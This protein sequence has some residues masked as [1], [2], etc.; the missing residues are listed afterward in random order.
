M[1]QPSGSRGNRAS[2]TRASPQT[3]WTSQRWPRTS[4]RTGFLWSC[5]IKRF[6]ASDHW[7]SWSELYDCM[8]SNGSSTC[9]TLSDSEYFRALARRWSGVQISRS[10]WTSTTRS[11][12]SRS[13][14]EMLPDTHWRLCWNMIIQ[15]HPKHRGVQFPR[16]STSIPHVIWVM[17][18]ST[19]RRI[20]SQHL[21][22]VAAA[23]WE[24]FF[25]AT[26]NMLII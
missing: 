20:A 10:F 4:L 17:S 22:L 6:K 2:S 12:N 5:F 13:H 7:V 9:D 11:D 21:H 19:T 18:Y 25:D 14:E 8:I 3:V 16:H 24:C 26:S 1:Q 23:L 15:H